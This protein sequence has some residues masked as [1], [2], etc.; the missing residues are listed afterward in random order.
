MG[1]K[2]PWYTITDG[3]TRTSASEI[4]GTAQRV[5]PRQRRGIPHVYL[6]NE[7]GD[8]AMG[9]IWSYLDI[10][11]L[12]RQET[13]EDSPKGYPRRPAAVQVVELATTTMTPRP[14]QTRKWVEVS[15]AK[16]ATFRKSDRGGQSMTGAENLSPRG[17][18]DLRNDGAAYGGFMAA[19]CLT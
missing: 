3:S 7:R 4:N 15:D 12:G 6:I 13:W 11:P 5:H 17:R 14:R 9:T 2:M 18:A 8:E 19:A 16:E 10:T 1:W